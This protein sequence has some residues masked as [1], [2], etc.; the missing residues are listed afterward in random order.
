MVRKLRA[1][2]TAQ[3]LIFGELLISPPPHRTWR[4]LDNSPQPVVIGNLSERQSGLNTG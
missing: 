3:I 1:K 2:G 4:R